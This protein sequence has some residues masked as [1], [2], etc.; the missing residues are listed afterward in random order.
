MSANAILSWLFD[1]YRT[2][3]KKSGFYAT[4]LAMRKQGFPFEITHAI[5]F[6][7]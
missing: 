4:A 7:V 1:K 6:G 2:K 5:L 3:A